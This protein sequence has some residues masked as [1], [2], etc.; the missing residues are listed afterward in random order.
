MINLN[1]NLKEESPESKDT[2][3]NKLNFYLDLVKLLQ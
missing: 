2:K 1:L 3:D